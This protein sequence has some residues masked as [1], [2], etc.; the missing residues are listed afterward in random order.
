MSLLG[1]LGVAAGCGLLAVLATP[2]LTALARNSSRWLTS[3]LHPLLAIL[4]G[5]GAAIWAQSVLELVVLALIALASALLITVDLAAHRLPNAIVAPPYPVVAGCWA[6]L[7]VLEEDYSGLWRA[8]LAG[9]GLAAAYLVLALISPSGLGLGDV[10]LAG[11]IGLVLGWYGWEH[12]LTGTIAAFV[13]GGL[14]ALVLL[15]SSKADR[16]THLPFGPWMVAGAVVGLLW[17][18]AVFGA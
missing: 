16:R 17:G 3:G 15:A 6:L 9:A 18:P 7:G 10:K 1:I 14:F 2:W 8:L 5:A 13:L 11:L 12:V 4:G